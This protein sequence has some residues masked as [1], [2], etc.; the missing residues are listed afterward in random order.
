MTNLIDIINAVVDTFNDE[1]ERGNY[2]PSLET[3]HVAAKA[4]LRYQHGDIVIMP[5]GER[6]VITKVN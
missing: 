5:N 4:K 3:A 6:R 1:A 2:R